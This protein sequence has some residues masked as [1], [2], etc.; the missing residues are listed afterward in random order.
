MIDLSERQPFAIG[1]RREC[2]VHPNHPGRCLKVIRQEFSPEKLRRES[3]FLRSLR[4]RERD[5]NENASDFSVLRGLE[6][7]GDPE[8]WNHLPQCYGM[9]QTSRG[10]AL[11]IKL[12]RDGD[13]LISRSLL[14]HL[15]RHGIDASLDRAIDLFCKFWISLAIP[16]RDLGLHNIVVCRDGD[17]VSLKLIDGFG[18]TQTPI[19][20]LIYPPAAK[21]RSVRKARR[22]RQEIDEF[23][24]NPNLATGTIARGVLLNRE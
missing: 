18:S 12:F 11:S 23:L 4:K 17:D 19:I 24:A 7:T 10:D 16:T 21:K 2:Y 5:F 1:G 3:G 20:A 6:K 9:E 15:T 13:G 8:I 14:D 22:L